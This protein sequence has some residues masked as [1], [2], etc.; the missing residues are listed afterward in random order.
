MSS[1]QFSN[2]KVLLAPLCRALGLQALC[3]DLLLRQARQGMGMEAPAMHRVLRL[4]PNLEQGPQGRIPE[5]CYPHQL[6]DQQQPLGFVLLPVPSHE[7]ERKHLPVRPIQ[8]RRHIPLPPRTPLHPL[9][10]LRLPTL[11]P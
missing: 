11:L 2:H 7:L 5:V 8:L 6:Q 9:I 10:L 4:L 1:E 3:S